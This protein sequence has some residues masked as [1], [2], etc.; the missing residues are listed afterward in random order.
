MPIK[1]DKETYEQVI[2]MVRN[3]DYTIGDLLDYEFF[4]QHYKLI[5]INLRN[6]LIL[7]EGLTE[8]KEQQCFILLNSPKKQF[9]N[10][11]K[12]LQQLFDFEHV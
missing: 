10:L 6:K 2:E 1:T 4:S 12:M 7:L 11:N 3:D 5:A 8:M 9:L